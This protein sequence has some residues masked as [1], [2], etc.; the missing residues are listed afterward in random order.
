MCRSLL[1]RPVTRAAQKGEAAK[2]LL[3]HAGVI[4]RL[5]EMGSRPSRHD[6]RHLTALRGY[7]T[8]TRKSST[9]ASR[10]AT[11]SVPDVLFAV[12]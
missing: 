4:E 6:A 12:A 8:S 10:L 2:D 9:R 1:T 5:G 3:M 11:D 7:R